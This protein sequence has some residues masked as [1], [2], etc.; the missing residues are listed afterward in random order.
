M[1]H[2]GGDYVGQLFDTYGFWENGHGSIFKG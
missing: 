1:G 2:V